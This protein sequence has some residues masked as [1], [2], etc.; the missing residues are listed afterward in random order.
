MDLHYRQELQV[1]FFVIAALALLVFGLVWLSGRSLAGSSFDVR[2]SNI[3]GVTKG[4]PVQISGVQ[5]GRVA[6]VRLRGV[7]EVILSLEVDPSVQPKS[8]ASASVR[9]LDFL[10]AKFI[11]YHPGVSDTPLAA[12]A[13]VTGTE[14]EDLAGM[15]TGLASS[16]DA[17]LSSSRG[18]FSEEMSD[19]IRHTMEA[20]ERGLNIMARVGDGPMISD[21]TQAITTLKSAVSRLDSL[22]ANPAIGESVSQLD[23]ITEGVR[24]MTEGLGLV[25]TSLASLLAKVDTSDGTIG[26][27]LNERTLHDDLHDLLQSMRA[28]LDDIRENPG[29]YGPRSIKLF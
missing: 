16:A 25:A 29:R 11:E 10:G 8:D 24:E 9:S 14:Q 6:N 13:V 27:L 5:V 3:Q 22:L 1:G 15:A 17:L 21:A 26:L 20:A 19:Q 7:G 23:E 2:F 18:F 12:G 4:D 28:L